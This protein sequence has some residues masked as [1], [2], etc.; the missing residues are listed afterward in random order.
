MNRLLEDAQSIFEAA[1][2][3]SAT[4]QAVSEF[5]LLMGA[6][7]GLHLVAASDWPLERLRAERGARAAYRVGE[8]HGKVRVEGCTGRLNCR[9][10]S[11]SPRQLARRLLQATPSPLPVETWRL[12][13]AA[14]G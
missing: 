2:A 14:S 1:C 13:R 5:T 6:E 12:L 9:L 3:L 10:E 7:G 4:G 11:E 8:R